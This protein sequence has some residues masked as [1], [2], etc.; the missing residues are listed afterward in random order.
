MYQVKYGAM[1]G[2]ETRILVCAQ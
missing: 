1:I 2:R